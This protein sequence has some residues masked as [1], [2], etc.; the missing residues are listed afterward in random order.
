MCDI[1]E[2]TAIKNRDAKLDSFV[3]LLKIQRQIGS[4]KQQ[5]VNKGGRIASNFVSG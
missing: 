1:L 5:F 3:S 4:S 2:I